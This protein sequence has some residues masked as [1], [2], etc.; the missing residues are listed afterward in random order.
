MMRT[1]WVARLVALLLLT[2]LVAAVG[3]VLMAGERLGSTHKNKV[4]G[5][6]LKT[7]FDWG[8]VP[9]QPGEGVIVGIWQGE[10]NLGVSPRLEVRRWHIEAETETNPD[11][12][13]GTKEKVEEKEPEKPD[14]LA[15]FRGP[16]NFGAWY[17]SWTRMTNVSVDKEIDLRSKK[18]ITGKYIEASSGTVKYALASYRHAGREFAILYRCADRDWKGAARVFLNSCKSFE[19]IEEEGPEEINVKNFSGTEAE[20]KRRLEAR[21]GLPGDWFAFDSEHYIFIS[22]AD[23]RLVKDISK[24]IELLRTNYFEKFFPPLAEITALSVVRVCKDKPTYHAYGGPPGSAGYW[25][26]IKEELV[27][28]QDQDNLQGSFET[29]HH[30]AFHQYIFY[31]LGD[32]SPHTW[33]NEGNADYFAGSKFSGG[34]FRI[35]GRVGRMQTMKGA[36]A[37]G[38]TYPLEKLINMSQ[39]EYY[40]DMSVCYAHGWSF[41]YFLRER[42][43]R[44]WKKI[45]PVY[46]DSLKLAWGNAL[47][48]VETDASE[49]IRSRSAA[50]GNT[51]GLAPVRS[52]DV[53]MS[54]MYA[55]EDEGQEKKDEDGLKIKITPPVGESKKQAARQYALDKA[56]EGVDLKALERAWIKA[57]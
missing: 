51:S 1:T 23:P 11:D 8:Q 2:T 52:W 28:Y 33:Y 18:G 56:F 14:P 12:L 9:T 32:I 26:S 13:L 20:Q 50:A 24:R 29:L 6:A 30:E 42:A 47:N 38:R 27:F 16:E 19:F 10:S 37:Q 44:K 3:G 45:L 5:Y 17:S 43:P 31:A 4:Y 36:I 25:W 34:R 39:R 49:S 55:Q 46:F 41:V 48:G 15:R 40:S 35:L 54:A 7:P 21:E 22:N 57:S 53:L